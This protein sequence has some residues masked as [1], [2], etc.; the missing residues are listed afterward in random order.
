[1]L[2][3][4]DRRIECAPQVP[5]AYWSQNADSALRPMIKL[6]IVLCFILA[7]L[8][9]CFPLDDLSAYA[10]DNSQEIPVITMRFLP[11][12][13]KWHCNR[14]RTTA[15]GWQPYWNQAWITSAK[16]TKSG[17]KSNPPKPYLEIGYNIASSNIRK[18]EVRKKHSQNHHHSQ[19][20]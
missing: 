16:T 12:L 6:L 4:S 10:K 3:N 7:V 11:Y 14:N 15:Y 18:S 5:P 20:S 17:K 1:M 19:Y 9:Q 8:A 2:R 13:N